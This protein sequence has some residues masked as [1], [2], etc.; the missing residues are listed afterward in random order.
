LFLAKKF[1]SLLIFT[2][3]TEEISILSLWTRAQVSA[4]FRVTSDRAIKLSNVGKL[5]QHWVLICAQSF[6]NSN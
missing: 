3:M 6:E 5:G 1:T 4:D 2:N